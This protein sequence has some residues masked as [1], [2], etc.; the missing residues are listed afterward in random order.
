V[1]RCPLRVVRLG[2]AVLVLCGALGGTLL[3]EQRAP[4]PQPLAVGRLADPRA[5]GGVA[6]PTSLGTPAQPAGQQPL[7]P[8]PVTRL[9][10]RLREDVLEAGRTFSLR[11]TEPVPVRDLLLLLVRDTRFSI[12]AAPGVEGVFVGELKDVTLKQALD[13][14]LHPLG[15][16]YAVEETFIRVFPR[17]LETRRFEVNALATA[18]TARRTLGGIVPS[19]AADWPT[20]AQVEVASTDKADVFDE[21]TAGVRTLL[22]PEG[23]FNLD[24]KAALL[25]VTDYPDRL[26]QVRLYLEAVEARLTRQV[27]IHA[28]VVEV[29]LDAAHAARGLDWRALLGDALTVTRASVPALLAGFERQGT[30]RVLAAPRLVAMNNEPAVM[31]IGREQVYF[32]PASAAPRTIAEGLTLSITPQISADGFVQMSVLPSVTEREAEAHVLEDEGGPALSVRETDTLV[33]VR[34]GETVVLGGF[35]RQRGGVRTDLVIL[36]APA[37]VTP[38]TAGEVAPPAT[39]PAPAG[40][41][42][43]G[44]GAGSP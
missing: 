5:Q 44:T 22:S 42:A 12:V 18:R 37:I 8:L 34:E 10:E 38:G 19:R 39:V 7:V 23:R 30:V 3:A 13:L 31:R 43:R 35:M 26:D 15:L 25:Q 9:E 11:L 14:V 32:G 6:A 4:S 17:R 28:W 2:A 27:A 36:L 29:E 21:L 1:V 33:R 41:S 20:G 40:G 24:R 16:E